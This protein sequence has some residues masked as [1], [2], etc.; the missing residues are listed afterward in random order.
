MAA[1]VDKVEEKAAEDL[2]RALKTS[3]NRAEADRMLNT[4]DVSYK[5]K[6]RTKEGEEQ[7]YQSNRD[8]HQ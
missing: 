5:V 1:N 7:E 8:V 4:A 3:K 6:D 2:E